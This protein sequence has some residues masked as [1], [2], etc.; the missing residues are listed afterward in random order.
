MATLTKL[1]P[2][3]KKTL[4]ALG[5]SLRDIRDM[6]EEGYS[7]EQMQEVA[8]GIVA[9]KQDDATRQAKATKRAM[10]PENETH[11]G[12]SALNPVGDETRSHW[13]KVR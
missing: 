13:R 5:V 8:E 2:E 7:F 6:Q 3:Q 10:R 12:I 9:Q 4:A 11:P 1:S